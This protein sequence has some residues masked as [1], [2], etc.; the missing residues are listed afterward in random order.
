M[1]LTVEWTPAASRDLRRLER[2]TA[3]RVRQTVIVFAET[4]HGDIA[5]LQSREPEW[6]LRAGDWRVRFTFTDG[7]RTLRVL[8]VLHRREAYR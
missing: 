3:Q 6:R 5:K 4:G 7:G 2:T 8:R 1:T